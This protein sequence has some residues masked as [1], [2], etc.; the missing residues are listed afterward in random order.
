M[1]YMLNKLYATLSQHLM[2]I[3]GITTDIIVTVVG[4][5]V[6]FFPLS[7]AELIQ[8][9]P[10]DCR[11]HK[12]KKSNNMLVFDDRFRRRSGLLEHYLNI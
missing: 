6:F 7:I 4:R 1:L 3:A 9:S 12:Y 2:R 8:A 10:D 5:F 11:K